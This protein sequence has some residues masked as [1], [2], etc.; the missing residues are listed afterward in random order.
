MDEE[1]EAMAAAG[2]WTMSEPAES[3]LDAVA[4]T[5]VGR[6]GG[7]FFTD[8]GTLVALVKDLDPVEES[9]VLSRLGLKEAGVRLASAR[10]AE[11]ELESFADLIDDDNVSAISIDVERSQLVLHV[12][13]EVGAADLS[14]LLGEVPTDAVRVELGEVYMQW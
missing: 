9:D 11:A 1:Q 13:H 14:K 12:G 7:A 6:F 3:A 8:D 10:Y 2:G 4:E 5:F